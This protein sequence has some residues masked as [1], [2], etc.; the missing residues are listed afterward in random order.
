[1]MV[2]IKAQM[3]ELVDALVSGTS[4][5]K[6]VEVRVFFWAPNFKQSFFKGCFFISMSIVC[7]RQIDFLDC[8]FIFFISII[9][10][11]FV[12]RYYIYSMDC[13]AELFQKQPD[14]HLKLANYFI[15][16]LVVQ[17]LIKR[18]LVRYVRFII[19]GRF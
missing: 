4:V 17:R 3:A 18:K 15:R 12:F 5:R 9:L 7:N 13:L 11:A 10:I 1:M 2:K 8:V 16:N 19:D 14:K 6:D